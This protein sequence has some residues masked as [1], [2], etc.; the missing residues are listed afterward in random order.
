M[1]LFS[2]FKSQHY[3]PTWV[4]KV[5]GQLWRIL[6]SHGRLVA[7]EHRKNEEKE[8]TFFCIDSRSG[9][10]IWSMSKK[11]EGWWTTT[12]GV[13]GNNLY[14]HA[15]AKP[16]LPHPKHITSIDMETGRVLWDHPEL[17]FLYVRGDA[18]VAEKREFEQTLCHRLDPKSGEI[19]D[20]IYDRE[21]IETERLEARA[22]DPHVKLRF[23]EIYNPEYADH[24]LFT[25][26]ISAIRRKERLVD[27]LEVLPFGN[28]LIMCYHKLNSSQ[29]N[30]N[31]P[32]THELII[33]DRNDLKELYRDVL[34]ENASAPA[35]DGFF[36]RE[37]VLYYVRN[38]TE[39]VAVTL[40]ETI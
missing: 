20:T 3:R 31:T 38:K 5:D 35:P 17:T 36:I 21:T 28:H 6:F 1:K 19:R 33:Y 16:D 22:N 29:S 14:L 40:Q 30:G 23:P 13:H 9:E 7:G 8:V 11:G 18:V 2:L 34:F 4:Y 37:N 24:R 25:Q 39:F 27:P 32:L 12:E 10:E 26:C 15:F